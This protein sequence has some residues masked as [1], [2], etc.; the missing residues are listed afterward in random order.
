VQCIPPTKTKENIMS[1]EIQS[2]DFAENGAR[3]HHTPRE[4]SVQTVASTE[5]VRVALE[6][7]ETA[8]AAPSMR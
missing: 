7:E 5:W 4:D 6:D 3:S 8:T 2:E 1:V